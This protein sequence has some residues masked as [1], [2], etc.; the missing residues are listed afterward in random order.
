MAYFYLVR[1]FG[2]VPIIHS[3]SESLG[4]GDYNSVSKVEKAD[5]YEYIIMTLEK[6]M[7]LLPKEK[8]TS[9]RIDYYCAEGLLSK[10]YLTKAGVS[11]TLNQEVLKKG[12]NQLFLDTNMDAGHGGASGRFEALKEL[13][14]EFT[15][16][17]DLEKITK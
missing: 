11:G 5:V 16:L 2:D 7:E 12:N 3:N 6:A 8:S 17:F 15:F 1:T 4:K 14:K 10:V 9:G 13:A